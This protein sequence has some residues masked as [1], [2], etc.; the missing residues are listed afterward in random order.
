MS[1]AD[2]SSGAKSGDKPA[3][4]RRG[5]VVW[6]SVLAVF[7]LVAVAGT[8][9]LIS[10]NNHQIE[11]KPA[12]AVTHASSPV[13]AAKSSLADDALAA[14][15][16][17]AMG[18]ASEDPGFGDLHAIVADASTG[19][20]LWSKN[21]DVAAMPASSLKIL[22]ASAALLGL[23]HGHRV[24]TKVL[25]YGNTR[26]IVVQ[27]AG[28]PTLSVDGNGFFHDAAS[29]ADLAAK[30]KAAMPEGVG[31]VYVDAS[32]FTETFHSTWDKQGLSDG[33]VADVKPTMIDAGRVDPTDENSPR[34]KTP[35]ADVATVLARALGAED[36]GDVADGVPLPA[37]EPTTVASVRSAPL[38][39]RIR[40][41]MLYSDN[42]LAESIAR[43]LA[44]KRG[45]PPTFEGAA[46]AVRSTLAEH[47]IRLD[48]AVLSD[49]SGLSTDDR[50]TPQHLATVLNAAVGPLREDEKT[51]GSDP[52]AAA[53]TVAL[54]PLL[55]CLPVA[56]VSGTLEGRFG[57][58]SGAGLVRAKTGTLDKASALAGYV[59]TKSGQV[60]SFVMLSN[61]AS[62]LPARAAADRAASALADI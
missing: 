4:K 42:V 18:V 39:T 51:S 2:S 23:D 54:R 28:D 55:D 25:R 7:V 16:S 41:M 27:G 8:V 12:P 5:W 38:I 6:L 43:E 53:V 33:Y 35:A 17:A 19:K 10:Y 49:S 48:G 9:A 32:L 29:I 34:S 1:S 3:A 60:L 46:E 11:V 24:E 30:V 40:D 31:K 52:E 50:V 62:I 59:V 45:L 56:S 47:G 44:V 14:K 15:V 13:T 21:D 20:S 57:Q 37:V 26:D 61:D 58:T 36:G 22:T